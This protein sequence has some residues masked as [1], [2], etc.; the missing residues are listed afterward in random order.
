MENQKLENLLNLALSATPQEREKSEELNVGYEGNGNMWE[1]I[2]KYHGDISRVG[3]EVVQVEPLLAGYAIV[4]IRED[5]IEAFAALE[6]VEYIEKPKRLFFS[7][8]EAKRAS[9]IPEVTKREPYLTGRGVVVGI[10]D[11]GIDYYHPD[12]RNEDGSTRIEALWD[13]TILP[14]AEKGWLPP[15]GFLT[16]VEFTREQIDAA[17]RAETRQAGYELVP[18]R[19]ISG[20][21]TAVAGIAA[22]NGRASGGAYEGVSPES[23]LIIVKLGTPRPEGF[24][25]TTELMRA[26]TYVVNQSEELGMPVALNLSFGN[27][28]GS[29]QGNSLLERFINNLSEVWKNVIC[30]GSGNEGAGMGHLAGRVTETQNVELSIGKYEPALSVQLWKEYADQMIVELEAP[31]G[32]IRRIETGRQETTRAD[33]G[34]TQ[35]L[36]YVGEPSPYSVM[37]EIYFDFLAEDTYLT[38]GVWTFRLIPQKVSQG[39]FQMYLPVS[40]VRSAGTRFF[41]PSPEFTLTIPSTAEKVITVA[42]YNSIYEAYADFSGRGYIYTIAGSRKE[43]AWQLKPD[44]AA[45]GVDIMAPVPGSEFDR[46]REAGVYEPV[47]GTSFATPIVSGAAALMMEWGIV[48]GYDP[49][50]YGEKV[51]AFMRKGA[52]ELRGELNLPNDRVGY[53]A[54]CLADSLPG[55][56]GSIL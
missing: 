29:H 52:R 17:L 36:I 38:D 28:Y 20:H 41:R 7:I 48:L 43:N 3:N 22:G 51:K 6:E 9:C 42:A 8:A 31:G 4:T 49:Y 47:T 50:L 13:Q 2:V 34:R 32:Q 21:G 23:T 12:F 39:Q 25:R 27:T 16:G 53:G 14:D 37:Q 30:V 26:M 1:L 44:I 18:S 46:S 54:L 5:L 40:E 11:S 24:P 33:F 10:I 56:F 19:D 35:V 45:P 15:M 55:A